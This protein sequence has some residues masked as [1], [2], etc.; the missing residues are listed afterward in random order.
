[1]K[2]NMINVSIIDD[3]K[4]LTEGL[5]C[6]LTRSPKLVVGD[7]GY[8][9]ADCRNLLKKRLPDVLI[10]DVKLPDGDGCD[11]CAELVKTYPDLKILML[12]FYSETAVVRRA[13][14]S[15]AK[16]YL[17]KNSDYEEFLEGISTVVSGGIFLCD[18]VEQ[19]LN[20]DTEK[21]VRLTKRELELLKFIAQGLINTEIAE[22]LYISEETVKVHRKN[23]NRKFSVHNTAQLVRIAME[24]GLV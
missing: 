2:N 20:Q 15:G 9:V 5:V 22:R 24:M 23:L 3:H 12:T 8:S 17:L 18:E 14:E 10:L 13:L 16:G 21:Q 6:M 19:L 11:L 1:M 4:V 7:V